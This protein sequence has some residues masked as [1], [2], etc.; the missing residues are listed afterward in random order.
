VII[1]Q[2]VR[3]TSA[4]LLLLFVFSTSRGNAAAYTAT[5]LHPLGRLAQ[6]LAYATSGGAQ[7]GIGLGTAN[8]SQFHAL[9]WNGSP[10]SAVDLNPA[11]MY[12]SQIVGASAANQVGSGR[13]LSNSKNHALLWS[14]TPNGVIDLNPSA[15]TESY[16]SAAFGAN[17][18]GYGFPNGAAAD[19]Y[20][21]LLW[22]GSAGS[23]V[24]LQPIGFTRTQALGIWGNTQV[25]SGT[26]SATGGQGHALLWNGTANSVVD[27]NPSWAEPGSSAKAVFEGTQVGNAAVGGWSHAAMWNGSA[28]TGIDLH[29]AGFVA[30][31]ALAVFGSMQVGDG[32]VSAIGTEIHALVWA[33]SAGSV[34]DLHQYVGGLPIALTNTFAT[35][36]SS[37]GTIVGFGTDNNFNNYAIMW[38]P[39]P[40][41]T[42]CMLLLAGLALGISPRR[43][44][45]RTK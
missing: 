34:V 6:S 2:H 7:F 27:L 4:A 35:A 40:E 23:V 11:G 5:L 3:R 26:G 44:S 32:R 24:D 19:Q 42:S 28:A 9:M 29:P 39:V 14:G 20:H 21:A 18:V 12:S 15:F 13:A 38:T 30:S 8:G 1:Q 16:S 37:N 41:P 17:Q 45:D 25:G 33:G 31:E 10:A 22:T 36:I 43:R